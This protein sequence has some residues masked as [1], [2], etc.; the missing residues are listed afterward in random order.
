M[1]A[2]LAYQHKNLSPPIWVAGC[3][4][5]ALNFLYVAAFVHWTPPSSAF[6]LVAALPFFAV[7]LP[8]FAVLLP[9]HNWAQLR[10]DCV[11]LTTA[12]G[13]HQQQITTN[14]HY[15]PK[16]GGT[17]SHLTQKRPISPPSRTKPT[18]AWCAHT[19]PH[20]HKRMVINAR[21]G[22]GCSP[23]PFLRASEPSGSLEAAWSFHSFQS[24]KSSKTFKAS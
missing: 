13:T 4:V 5:W 7:L 8:F 20:G 2:V 12:N 23:L 11:P 19:S 24:S 17:T 22:G 21:W 14:A 15:R 9:K 18:A 6:G 16:I 10:T 3:W 1:F